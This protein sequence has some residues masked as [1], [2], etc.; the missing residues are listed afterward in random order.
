M[1]DTAAKEAVWMDG[2]SADGLGT[3]ERRKKGW[4]VRM[5]AASGLEDPEERV[6]SSLAWARVGWWRGGCWTDR[7]HRVVRPCRTTKSSWAE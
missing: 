2:S 4:V 5:E 3:Y 1:A 7:F 6:W